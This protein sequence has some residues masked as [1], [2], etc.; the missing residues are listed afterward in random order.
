MAECVEIWLSK[1]PELH[2]LTNY[3]SS[4]GRIVSN[5]MATSLLVW[6]ARNKP[7]Y[8]PMETICNVAFPTRY[9]LW[10]EA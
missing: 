1:L 2:K 4:N 9:R 8:L 6:N 3:G 5:A 10:L 7:V